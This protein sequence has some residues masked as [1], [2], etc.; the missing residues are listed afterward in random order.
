[1]PILCY[2]PITSYTIIG[3]GVVL[4]ILQSNHLFFQK[5]R[6]CSRCI[7][8]C[9]DV[10]VTLGAGW[11]NWQILRLF[12]LF[13]APIATQV[14]LC[15]C[16]AVFV[17]TDS[18]PAHDSRVG[19]LVQNT[20]EA[21]LVYQFCET[22]VRSGINESKIGVISLYRQQVK[23]LQN[24]L[25]NRPAVEVLTADRS[26]GRDKDVIIISLVRSND[27][28]LVYLILLLHNLRD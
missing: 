14:S 4:P 5:K 12:Y 18:L 13:F 7:L 20:T 9:K 28:G 19:D 2:F 8:T 26:Q 23:L 25:Q 16:K 21:N 6:S 22:L 27:D 15:R 17:D 3:Y 10:L 1:M 24:M 11:S